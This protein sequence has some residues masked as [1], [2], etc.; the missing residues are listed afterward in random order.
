VIETVIYRGFDTHYILRMPRG[1][2]RNKL[3]RDDV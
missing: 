3:V 1:A 2:P